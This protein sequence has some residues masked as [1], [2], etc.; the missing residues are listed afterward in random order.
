MMPVAI[1]AGGLG[2]RMRPLTE[3]LPKALLPVAGR[4]FIHWQLELLARAGLTRAVICAGF[5]G[6][7]IE[8]AVGDGRRF[9][10]EVR[11]AWDGAAPRG[12]GGALRSALP[13]LGTDFFVLYGDTYLACSF[14]AVEAAYHAGGGQAL[15]CV[16]RNA[17][18]FDRSNTV[19]R[20]GR[21]TEHDKRE[22]H[23]GMDYI[24][25]GLSILPAACLAGWQQAEAFDL[26]D[27]YR[28]LAQQGVL[29]GFEV[30][31]RFHEIGSPQGLIDTE[32]LLAG[33]RGLTA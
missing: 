28:Q 24:D 29:K 26:G 5:L 33:P 12:T 4:P 2:T 1:L 16:L 11:Y 8:A 13:L 19:Y 10:L 22:P 7:Q 14:A 20:N 23:A 21:V 17:G 30:Y 27:V 6:E 15:L 25:Y 18:R 32:R 3:Q 31:E 9:G